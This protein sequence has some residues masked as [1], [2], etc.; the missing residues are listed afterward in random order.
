MLKSLKTKILASMIFLTSVCTITYMGVS[1]FA[2]TKAVTNQM[3]NDGA[4]LVAIINREIAKHDL[5]DTGAIG[6]TLKEIKT[7]SDENIAYIS[8]ADTKLN[9]VASSDEGSGSSD[10]ENSS[11]ESPDAVSSATAKEESSVAGNI[12]Q[13]KASGYI[14]ETE[15]GE[16]VY[17]VSAP[18]YEKGNLAGTISIGISL[19]NMNNMVYM[20]L[21]ETALIALLVELLTIIAGIFISKSITKP[22]TNTVDKLE[23]FGRGDFTVKFENKSKDETRRLTDTLNSSIVLLKQMLMQVKQGMEELKNIS[24]NLK[25]SSKDVGNSSK[26]ISESIAEVAQGIEEQDGN[27]ESVNTVL[28]S[29]GRSVDNIEKRMEYTARSSSSIE[30]AADVGALKLK[31][32]VEAIDS[33]RNSFKASTSSIEHLNKDAR[34]IGEIMNVIN[35]VAEQTN[36]LALNAAIEAARAGEAGKGFSVVA[37]EIRKLAEQVMEYSKNINSIVSGIASNIQEVSSA[38]DDISNKM[39]RQISM[40]DGTMSAFKNI[41]SEVHK[42]TP[43]LSSIMESVKDVIKV[44]EEIINSV[45]EVSAISQQISASTEEISASSEEHAATTEQ[46]TDL[47]LKIDDMVCKINES[48]DKFK[49]K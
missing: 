16:K 34:K 22:I 46:L 35:S 30:N 40:I 13:G 36:L 49:I 29:F 28:E 38:S 23:H 4:N 37:E 3:K 9:I 32:L 31:E 48:V 41:Q 1:Y 43:E 27:I 18:F 44:E 17:N 15:S 26:S 25:V 7:Q 42:T 10:S 8:L 14:F 19:R 21:A 45:R 33:V 24:N 47:S 2:M 12:K 11:K 39:D 6:R 20:Q 5:A